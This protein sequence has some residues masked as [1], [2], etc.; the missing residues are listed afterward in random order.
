MLRD[1]I[2]EKFPLL[3]SREGGLRDELGKSA[4]GELTSRVLYGEE[5]G[6]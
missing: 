3:F 5:N 4:V 6:H 2:L 1:E